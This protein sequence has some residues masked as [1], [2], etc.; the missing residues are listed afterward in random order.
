MYL[1]DNSLEQYYRVFV[2]LIAEHDVKTY[3]IVTNLY[4]IERRLRRFI[5][6]WIL[7]KSV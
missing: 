1:N 6:A 3:F 4:R 5:N 7:T 2:I